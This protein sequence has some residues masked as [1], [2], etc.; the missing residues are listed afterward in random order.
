VQRHALGQQLPRRHDAID[1]DEHTDHVPHVDADAH[2]DDH[3][4]CRDY[5]Y[6][7][8]DYT[9]H[10]DADHDNGHDD[11]TDR[12]DADH[13]NGHD[14]GNDDDDDGNACSRDLVVL[15]GEGK[16][17]KLRDDQRR[18]PRRR[19]ICLVQRQAGL[20][21]RRRFALSDQSRR[22]IRGVV[23][24]DHHHDGRGHG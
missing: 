18:E 13:D 10:D 2:A 11:Y 12:D 7:D 1:V 24:P 3:H 8:H 14:D 9:D 6:G 23:R 17:R 21:Q 5:D 4:D 19:A 15:A 16:P 20:V 22:S